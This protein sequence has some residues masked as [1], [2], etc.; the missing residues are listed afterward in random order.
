MSEDELTKKRGSPPKRPPKTRKLDPEATAPR[1]VQKRRDQITR[2]P[3]LHLTTAE[4]KFCT[5]KVAGLTD[6]EALKAAGIRT[7]GTRARMRAWRLKQKPLIKAA[8][9]EM[10]SASLEAVQVTPEKI[11]GKL[12][13][14]AFLPPEMLDGKPTPRDQLAALT[15]LAEIAKLVDKTK[16]TTAD[17]NIINII[18]QSIAPKTAPVVSPV[19]VHE[20]ALLRPDSSGT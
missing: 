3:L 16:P 2:S 14:V 5:A 17:H 6:E 11:V 1:E 15:K 9:H 7:D 20:P 13:Y 19:I 10:A 8:I 4:M 12:A 18:T